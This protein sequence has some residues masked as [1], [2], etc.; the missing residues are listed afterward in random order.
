MNYFKILDTVESSSNDDWTKVE[1]VTTPEG[2][3]TVFV[4]HEDASIT[5]AWGMPHEDG[6]SWTEK[7]SESGGFPDK[8]IF[9]HYFDIRYNGVPI[10]RDLVLAVDGHRCL[11]PSGSVIAED[12]VGITGMRV[13][14]PELRRARLLDNLVHGPMSKFERYSRSANIQVA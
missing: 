6:E 7:W 5:I 2:H 10:N 8:R 4:F 13:T 1:S 9:G 12:E 14:E 3:H 11:L